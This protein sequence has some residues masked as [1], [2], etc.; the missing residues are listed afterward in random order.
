[1]VGMLGLVI[2]AALLL[3]LSLITDLPGASHKLASA[4]GYGEA[5]PRGWQTF[6]LVGIEG[7]QLCIW[8]AVVWRTRRIFTALRAED[9]QCAGIAAGQTARLFRLMLA[10]ALLAHTLAPLVATWHFAPGTRVL[11]IGLG[12]EQL[13][14]TFA[15]LL[16][17]FTA[18]AF[19]P[20]A[21]LWQDHRELI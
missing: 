10:R 1:M 17:G 16:A 3:G 4:A 19:A 14:M 12:S 20:G 5:A 6:A 7:V 15:A 11:A 8:A 9:V 18:K 2:G 13:S 21:A